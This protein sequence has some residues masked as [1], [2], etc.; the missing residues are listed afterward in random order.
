MYGLY[1]SGFVSRSALAAI[2]LAFVLSVTAKP[3]AAGM[4]VAEGKRSHYIADQDEGI[5]YVV[6]GDG[7]WVR[8]A[9]GFGRI[10]GL[11]VCPDNSLYVLSSSQRRVIKVAADGRIMAVKKLSALPEAIYVDRDGEVKFVQRSGVVTGNK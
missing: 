11:A 2:V 10:S 5:V 7:E 9:D 8:F 6:Y 4:L 3:S 1:F